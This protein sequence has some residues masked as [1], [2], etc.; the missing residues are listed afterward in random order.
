MAEA[1]PSRVAAHSWDEAGDSPDEAKNPSHASEHVQSDGGPIPQCAQCVIG[2]QEDGTLAM[3]APWGTKGE[4]KRVA[5]DED[6]QDRGRDEQ[7]ATHIE[8]SLLVS[9]PSSF[10]IGSDVLE[11]S[12]SMGLCP[13]TVL[14]GAPFDTKGE[15]EIVVV[16]EVGQ[17][18]GREEHAATYVEASMLMSCPSS[19]AVKL[20]VNKTS[21]RFLSCPPSESGSIPLQLEPPTAADKSASSGSCRIFAAHLVSAG[22]I[23]EP[24]QGNG[25]EASSPEMLPVSSFR[26]AGVA[27]SAAAS[28]Y[29]AALESVTDDEQEAPRR[30]SRMWI[31]AMS[32]S[33][34]MEAL[35]ADD[36]S[37]SAQRPPDSNATRSAAN[38]QNRCAPDLVASE[39]TR[40]ECLPLAA[41]A[42][43][44]LNVHEQAGIEGLVGVEP[45]QLSRRHSISPPIAL[46]AGATELPEENDEVV[47]QA[48]RILHELDISLVASKS[49]MEGG[50]HLQAMKIVTDIVMKGSVPLPRPSLKTAVCLGALVSKT[51]EPPPHP[52]AVVRDERRRLLVASALYE[53]GKMLQKLSL[54]S[55]AADDF[56]KCIEWLPDQSYDPERL[57][58]EV[59]WAKAQLLAEQQAFSECLT[60][61]DELLAPPCGH[62]CTWMQLAAAEEVTALELR[63]RC[64]AS[65]G[66][67]EEALDEL[68]VLIQR[69]NSLSSARRTAANIYMRRGELHSALRELKAASIL[70]PQDTELCEETLELF[71][72]E[73]CPRRSIDRRA[74]ASQRTGFARALSSLFSSLPCHR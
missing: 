3:G 42:E 8:A 45:R 36:K 39:R 49:E 58:R 69:H 44:S 9:R 30:N 52:A 13:P 18:R 67:D 34:E 5:V 65:L 16:D 28:E 63:A 7:A 66:K 6:G 31:P 74:N 14:T 43:S 35:F 51:D 1:R 22:P 56:V 46:E 72:A 38:E 41:C 50:N 15:A 59:R 48:N 24:W 2:D 29:T 23:L 32:Y 57:G 17:D 64:L 68:H 21:S 27:R 19:P 4:V 40:D 26:D 10:A 54:W 25:E 55:S 33:A 11:P 70:M 47:E 71:A 73:V 60:A 20:N 61:L 12:S 53:R 37:G 62:A